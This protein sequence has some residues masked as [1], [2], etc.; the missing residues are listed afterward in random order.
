MFASLT[1][2]RSITGA[3]PAQAHKSAGPMCCHLVAH[4]YCQ[5]VEWLAGAL[6]E[7]RLE[8]GNGGGRKVGLAEFKSIGYI[9]LY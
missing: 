2:G 9:A 8:G 7:G 5:I 3:S 6:E 4:M 1:V